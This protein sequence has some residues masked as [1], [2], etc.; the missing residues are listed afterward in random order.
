MHID[1]AAADYAM[2]RR[3]FATFRCHVFADT[4]FFH[5]F[6]PPLIFAMPTRYFHALMP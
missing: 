5:T 4:P 6:L 1:Y 3:H 2:P